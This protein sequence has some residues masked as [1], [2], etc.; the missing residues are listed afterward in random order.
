MLTIYLNMG[1]TTLAGPLDNV[2]QVTIVGTGLLGGSCGLALRAAGFQGRIVGVGRNLDT[3]ERARKRGCLDVA[4]TELGMATRDSQLV[5]VATPLSSFPTIL[6]ELAR[7]IHKAAVV[8]DV[9]STKQEVCAT[10]RRLLPVPSR[11]IGSHP[12]AG[13]EQHGPDAADADLFKNK[14][15]II[16]PEPDADPAALR[17]VEGL[18][19]ALE[20]RLIRMSP[21]QHDRRVAG[22]SHLPHAI[23]V[24]L[25]E[26]AVSTGGLDLASTGFRD[27]TRLASGDPAI[28]QDVFTTNREALTE[29][30]DAFAARL[31][32]FRELLASRD[33]QGL[34]KWLQDNKDARDKW[35]RGFTRQTTQPDVDEG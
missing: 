19:T 28:W 32:K 27:T 1:T 3:V 10:A 14:P 18:W 25:V 30:I 5:V 4:S 20:M 12:M 24:L 26:L 16:T 34:L 9:G 22:I 11:F 6:K 15:C 7:N 35:A 21:A 31:A 2:K 29:T 23:S 13:S 8:T 17:L 33:H